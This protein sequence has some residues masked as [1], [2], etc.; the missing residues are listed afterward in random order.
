[1]TPLSKIKQQWT[2]EEYKNHKEK[3]KIYINTQ[4]IAKCNYINVDK[5]SGNSFQLFYRE[6][7]FFGNLIF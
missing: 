7:G 1:L 3:L 5:S 4:K 6:M 2:Y